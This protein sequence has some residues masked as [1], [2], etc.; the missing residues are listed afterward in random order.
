[1]LAQAVSTDRLFLLTSA[2]IAMGF[3]GLVTWDGVFP[4]R[5]DA[6]ILGPLPISLRTLMLARLGAVC[7]MF[8][9]FFCVTQLPGAV[10]FGVVGGTSTVPAEW[11]AAPRVRSS[12]RDWRRRSRSSRSSRCNARC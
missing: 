11:C 8:G 5:R 2:M 9:L 10:I 1:M 12:P 4:D 3:L 7:Y 6:R